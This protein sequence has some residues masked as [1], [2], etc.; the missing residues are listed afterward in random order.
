MNDFLTSPG[1]F[2]V[3]CNYWAS[4]AGTRMWSDWQPEVVDADLRQLAD[5]GL[6]VLRV[7]PLWPDF[8]PLTLLRGGAGSPREYRL[9][10]QP[11]PDTDAGRAGVSEE[12]MERFAFFADRAEQYGL[13]LV[14]GLLTGW[15]SGRLFVPPALE[16][17]NVLTDPVA[18]QWETR[19]VRYF[20][21]RFKEA[22][23]IT[24]WDLGN[25][26]NVMAAVPSPEA[27]WA[28][29]SA[30][31][32]A[33][34]V[35]DP[36]RPIV[37]GM[38]GELETWSPSTLGELTDLLT[39]HPYPFW[40]KYCDSDPVN[41]IRSILH[42][43]SESRLY[44]DWGDKPC[45]AE[46][47]GT[48]GPMLASDAIAA[49]FVR[50]CLFSL[51]AHDCHGLLWWCAYDQDRLPHAPYDWN[52]C[53][54]ELGLIRADRT[55]KPALAELG[56]F[57]QWL[58]GL[59]F[60]HL[61]TH[62]R[63]AVC[64]LS[65]EQD[66]WAA[67]YS[68]FILARQ[69]G[70]EVEFQQGEQPLKEA[71]LYL[72]P[73]VKGIN[74]ISRHRWLA[75][76]ER[77]RAGATLYVSLDGALLDRFQETYGLQAQTRQR[78]AVPEMRFTIDGIGELRLP[79]TFRLDL[80]P[81]GAQVLGREPDGN[82]AFSSFAYGSGRVFLL[83]APLEVALASLPEAFHAPGA[84][85]YWKI[86][87]QVAAG[88]IAKRAVR[89]SHPMLGVTEHAFSAEARVVIVINY[90]P[91]PARDALALAPG[92]QISPAWRGEINGGA[93]SVPG[94]DALV[95]SICR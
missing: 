54:R 17:L 67:A 83:T 47:L 8:Q 16:G 19:F 88:I 34:R 3:G 14:V 21:R 25:E 13:K 58:A 89:K 20:V 84:Q 59:P 75:L 73:S 56:R 95:F 39:T 31:T 2:V 1:A 82:P 70:F 81:A 53:E 86:Y 48:L 33:I 76:L 15:M 78:R 72:V 11:L 22:P 94:N 87:Q 85:P 55:P 42:S 6:Q 74:V 61:P 46:E 71:A 4:H 45:I 26:C 68:T 40:T 90:S 35:E 36:A 65:Q 18:I 62:P 44:A 30:I 64:L 5:G 43:T 60:D 80:N 32:S 9:G 79:S 37:S 57:R 29:V 7:F 49:D 23:A 10:E 91:E 27:A 24:A 69:A 93:V 66:Q 52:T 50:A 38:H 63:E 28:W 41:T 77:V 51:W 92:W 12:A